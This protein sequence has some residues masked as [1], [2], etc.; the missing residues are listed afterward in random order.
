MG[1]LAFCPLRLSA[2]SVTIAWDPNPN[3]DSVSNV[4]GYLLHYGNDGKR[5]TG[6]VNAGTNTSVTLTK[7]VPG[8]LVYF[9]V[10]AYDEYADA[11]PPSTRI[12]YVVVNS[13]IVPTNIITNSVLETTET[14]D[15]TTGFALLISGNGTISP[16]PNAQA[17]HAD[18]QYTL[19]ASPRRGSVLANWVSNSIVVTNT[20][21][22]TLNIESGLVLQANF[23]NTPF[24][25]TVTTYHGL[26]YVPTTNAPEDSPDD[27]D[28]GPFTA[29]ATEDTSGCFT[30][31]VTSTGAFSAKLQLQGQTYT[32]SGQFLLPIG[33]NSS[34]SVAPPKSIA[35]AR[36]LPPLIVTNLALDLTTNFPMTGFVIGT[37]SNG[38]W[39]ATLLAY[40]VVYAR[41]NQATNWMGKYTMVI[42]GSTNASEPGG[43]GFGEVT[44]ND[45]GAVSLSG[46]L[47]DGTSVT[48]TSYVSSDGQWPLYVSLYGGKGSILG[49]LSFTNNDASSILLGS[50][51][52]TN[53]S[54]H[55]I[56]GQISWFK[57]NQPTAKLYPEGFTNS[58]EVLGSWYTNLADLGF[59]NNQLSF[60][61]TNGD[62]SITNQ[63]VLGPNNEATNASD[64]KLTFKTASGLFS[65]SVKNPPGTPITV[66]GI[67][68]QDQ[69]IGAGYFLG[70]ANSGSVLLS[71]APQNAPSFALELKP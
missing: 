58:T 3:N 54:T 1:L 50:L 35:R 40:P 67:V 34:V 8:T 22:Y 52:L 57:T 17:Y 62:L 46:I 71:P 18:R 45:L 64:D 4:I 36:G 14:S 27:A 19:T 2:Q 24:T 49:W 41:T 25:N 70:T 68:L 56:S 29:G 16:S 9:E 48:S 11:S 12:Q 43:N 30:A 15:T 60:A 69:N 6:L 53:N 47:G 51:S 39:T 13:L 38:A 26:F 7:L 42:P 65:G 37:N 20:S 31:A 5:F 66:K 10:I 32:Y 23:T 61:L 55:S 44:V 28:G 33:T 59:T 63:V 21:K